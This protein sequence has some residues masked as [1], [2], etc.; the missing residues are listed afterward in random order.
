M[1]NSP[2]TTTHVS[3]SE[4]NTAQDCGM[5]WFAQWHLG[6][7]STGIEGKAQRVGSLG[8]ACLAAHVQA[9]ARGEAMHP[10]DLY[11]AMLAEARK[12]RYLPDDA[13]WCD[14]PQDLLDHAHLAH[15]A[16]HT[17][18][19]SPEFDVRRPVVLGGVPLVEHRLHASWA[20][21]ER[22]GLTLP[23]A[24]L[25]TFLG[26]N[27]RDARHTPH[28][29][30]M[31]G[32]PDVV[33]YEDDSDDSPVLDDDYKL[34]T[35]PVDGTPTDQAIADPQGAFYKVLLAAVGADD[36]RRDVVFRQ[37]NVYAGPWLT[38]EDFLL[39]GSE[40]V[41]SSGL[42]TRDT[43]RMPGLVRAEV[44]HAAWQALEERRRLATSDA[45][46]GPRL[47]TAAEY[48]DHNRFIEDLQRVRPVQVSRWR[49]DHTVCLEV[50]RDMLSAVAARL[51]QVDAGITPGRNL[52][53]WSSAPCV[54]PFGCDVQSPCL[55]SLGSGNA[56]AVFRDHLGAGRYRL[57][58]LPE[59]GDHDEAA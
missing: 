38:V 26:A 1:F 49:L 41:V 40:L 43:K 50:V 48:H 53:T 6:L 30:G 39:P 8:H 37:V 2:N 57:P 32:T 22:V 13:D 10:P 42:P 27:R 59:V 18:L 29:L 52:R 9:I 5:R 20:E 21:L 56:E 58:V 23:P 14:A 24:I 25:A 12:R 17:L 11:A 33:H 44:W 45:P 28:R 7:R 35:K 36:G 47:P 4:S 55:A 34:R 51:A 19:T 16:A 15:Q 46:K 31:E 3:Q 54:R